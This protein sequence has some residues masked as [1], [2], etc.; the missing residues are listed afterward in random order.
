M[1]K[2]AHSPTETEART[3]I[4]GAYFTLVE[5]LVVIA[6][7]MV[8]SALLLPAL[9]QARENA[10]R[11]FCVGNMKQS[12][13]LCQLY[14]TDHSD[15]ILPGWAPGTMAESKTLSAAARHWYR[16]LLVNYLNRSTWEF[17][18][19]ILLCPSDE[20]NQETYSVS[21][22]KI[23]NY[24]YNGRFGWSDGGSPASFSSTNPP[25][26]IVQVLSPSYRA[27]LMDGTNKSNVTEPCCFDYSNS[28]RGK[29]IDSRHQ[30]RTN[31]Q[32]LDGHADSQGKG[33]LLRRSFIWWYEGTE[34]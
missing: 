12:G 1:M 10:K 19:K 23:V 16:Q 11:L 34:Y 18:D 13:T 17:S 26:R 5:L 20:N 2:T 14:E 31:V 29:Y 22:C 24:A 32:Y 27:R 8:L 15:W 25:A 4:S 28:E 6:I 21:S 9:G 7:V 30:A 33:D 3:S